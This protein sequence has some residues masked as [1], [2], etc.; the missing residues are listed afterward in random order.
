MD[1]RRTIRRIGQLIM[2][3]GLLAVGAGCVVMIL[4]GLCYVL[5]I[6]ILL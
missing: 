3:M 2:V 6:L 5:V 4:A 1:T